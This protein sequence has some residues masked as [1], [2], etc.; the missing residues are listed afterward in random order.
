MFILAYIY[1]CTYVCSRTENKMRNSLVTLSA[2]RMYVYTRMYSYVCTS[3]TPI[4][5]L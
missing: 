4:S 5:V 2:Q 3:C 1:V